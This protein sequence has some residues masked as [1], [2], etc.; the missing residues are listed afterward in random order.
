MTADITILGTA[1]DGGFPHFGCTCARCE[2]ARREPGLARAVA[3][4]GVA[5]EASGRRFL[6]DATPDLASQWLALG[7]PDEIWLTHGHTGHYA[8]LLH[9]GKESLNVRGLTLR[10][11]ASMLGLLRD[12]AP[13]SM[14]LESGALTPSEIRPGV[15]FRPAPDLEAIPVAVPH[16]AEHT[17]TV[18][19]EIRGPA[20]ALFYAPD[21]DGFASW[22][23]ELAAI[24]GRVDTI[25]IDGTFWSRD[26][27]PGR[28][29]SQIPHPF[30]S[31]ELDFLATLA[32]RCA[33]LLTH[34]NHT[35]PL[36]DPGSEERGA[37]ERAGVE[38]A[39]DG[40]RRR[41]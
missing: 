27:L 15:A 23:D 8:G 3:S 14:L 38:V 12:N 33:V 35:N 19:F 32:R 39:A 37:V 7:R 17:D 9:L 20:G 25:V 16:R 36:V 28:D 24:A 4:L 18:G 22:A 26:E 29:L 1:Q 10:A 5:D 41:I 11:T 40:A 31:E 13:W 2:R 30:V 6:I 34:L 21:T